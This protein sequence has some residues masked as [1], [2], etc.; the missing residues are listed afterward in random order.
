MDR[1]IREKKVIGQDA[2][3]EQMNRLEAVRRL[4]LRVEAVH[5]VSWLWRSPSPTVAGGSV[6]STRRVD[7]AST[8]LRD[9]LPILRRRAG[10]RRVLLGALFRYVARCCVWRFQGHVCDDDVCLVP[11]W[12]VF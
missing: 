2:T 9:M 6:E 12:H 11:A 1:A 5:A 10:R 8:P 7:T 4:L 3:E